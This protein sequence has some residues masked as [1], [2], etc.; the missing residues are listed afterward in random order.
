MVGKRR[1]QINM[2]RLD[3]YA[4]SGGVGLEKRETSNAAWG[5]AA[6]AE[7]MHGWQELADCFSLENAD[8]EVASS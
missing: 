8:V 2:P 5:M 1:N 6:L 3:A 4:V 7:Q